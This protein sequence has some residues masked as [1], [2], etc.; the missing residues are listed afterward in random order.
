MKS[1]KRVFSS[2][3]DLFQSYMHLSWFWFPLLLAAIHT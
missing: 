3:F 1:E 2:I